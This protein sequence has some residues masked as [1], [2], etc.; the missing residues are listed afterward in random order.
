MEDEIEAVEEVVT[1]RVCLL[2]HFLK[3]FVSN[4]KFF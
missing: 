4:S 2:L 1:E 3:V